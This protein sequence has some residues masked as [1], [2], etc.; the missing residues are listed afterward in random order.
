[1]D[2]NGSN[3][4]MAKTM[5]KLI[6]TLIFIPSLAFG[7]VDKALHFGAGALI[8]SYTYCISNSFPNVS[9]VDSA[10]IAAFTVTMVGA[11]KEL[12]DKKADLKDF[13][14]TEMGGAVGITATYF[15]ARKYFKRQSFFFDT[16]TISDKRFTVI[17]YRKTF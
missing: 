15:L 4:I 2:T 6:L 17:G 1:M 9:N 12:I 5:K 11:G 16:R 8:G 10:C 13:A 3:L 14:A 7:Q